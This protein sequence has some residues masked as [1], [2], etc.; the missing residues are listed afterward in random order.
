MH[1]FWLINLWFIQ[2]QNLSFKMKI[3]LNDGIDI[4]FDVKKGKKLLE[5]RNLLAISE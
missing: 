3:R 5:T 2:H 4:R 1:W